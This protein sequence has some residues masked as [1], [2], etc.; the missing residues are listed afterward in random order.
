M[1]QNSNTA[2]TYNSRFSKTMEQIQEEIRE[3]REWIGGDWVED[4]DSEDEEEGESGVKGGVEKVGGKVG[5]GKRSVRLL[6]YACGT[7]SVSRVRTI[8]L[9]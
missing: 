8:F 6:D 4:S 7:G 1:T 5:G 3:R 2:A 9:K